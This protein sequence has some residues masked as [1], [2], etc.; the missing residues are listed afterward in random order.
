[1]N[2]TSMFTVPII[3]SIVMPGAGAP[4]TMLSIAQECLH[5]M[6]TPGDVRD[7]CV[8]AR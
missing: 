3:I 4:A 2:V 6:A 8:V 1:M 5:L 7:T